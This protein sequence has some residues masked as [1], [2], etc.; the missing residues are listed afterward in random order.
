MTT[1]RQWAS[2]QTCNGTFDLQV[3]LFRG[4][5]AISVPDI[6]G[7]HL[8]LLEENSAVAGSPLIQG[9]G[10]YWDGA[11]WKIVF[12]I[13]VNGFIVQ[14]E[15]LDIYADV[16]YGQDLSTMLSQ[17]WSATWVAD[18]AYPPGR[19]LLNTAA[20]PDSLDVGFA[21]HE[22][23]FA[24]HSGWYVQFRF[25]LE[26]E[27]CGNVVMASSTAPYVWF[28]PNPPPL[29]TPTPTFTPSNTPTW[30]PTYTLT[31]TPEATDT[32]TAGPTPT[33]TATPTP[34][35][36]PTAVPASQRKIRVLRRVGSSL[37]AED[38]IR[39]DE[40][41]SGTEVR[42]NHKFKIPGVDVFMPRAREGHVVY[43]AP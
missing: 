33:Y 24:G 6:T 31:P 7:T 35:A 19:A 12:R 16:R 10:I 42:W 32:P 13:T 40:V 17:A 39:A 8:I 14:D 4:D 37:I 43:N 26:T 9:E 2:A 3:E 30:T 1:T 18:A 23:N 22:T 41:R 21:L 34:T 27:S 20:D 5:D 11:Q 29:A 38:L 28:D 15:L 25:E 36:T